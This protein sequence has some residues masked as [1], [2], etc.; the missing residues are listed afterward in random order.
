MLPEFSG[1]RKTTNS[2]KFYFCSPLSLCFRLSVSSCWFC[3]TGRAK[4]CSFEIKSVKKMWE[5]NRH[6]GVVLGERGEGKRGN[7][8][9][10]KR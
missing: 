9:S 2:K 5:K 7:Q 4:H 6:K 8:K 10:V 1:K 3:F